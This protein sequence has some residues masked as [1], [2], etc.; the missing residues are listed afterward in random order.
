MCDGGWMG[1]ARACEWMWLCQCLHVCGGG[2][3]GADVGSVPKL[4]SHKFG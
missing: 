1:G 4:L 2:G 3:G